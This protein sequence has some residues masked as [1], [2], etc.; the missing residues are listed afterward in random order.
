MQTY[1]TLG[2]D[3]VVGRKL[4]SLLHKAG[5]KPVRTTWVFFGTCSGYPY[6]NIYIDNITAVITQA[7]EQMVRQRLFDEQKFDQ[8]MISL[9]EWRQ[10]LDAALWYAVSWAEGIKE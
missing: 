9:Q 5:A 3:P 2:N 4:V 7:K 1:R 10:K 6:F 8:V